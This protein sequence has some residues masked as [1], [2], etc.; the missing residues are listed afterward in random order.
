MIL[1][2]I[3][4]E[5]VRIAFTRQLT[6]DIFHIGIECEQI[7][8]GAQSGQFIMIKVSEGYEP[9][10]RRP[11]SILDYD[12]SRGIV[13]F[14]FRVV[15]KGTRILSNLHVG[16]RLWALGPLGSGFT[17]DKSFSNAVLVGGG[18]GIPPLYYLLKKLRDADK[19]VIFYYG[20]KSKNEFL[21]EERFRELGLEVRLA[22][23]DGTAGFH[24]FITELFL[25]DFRTK[26]WDEKAKI[27]AC[28][29]EPMLYFIHR[30]AQENHYS[31]ELSLETKMACGLGICQGCAVKAAGNS[32]LEYSYQLVCKDGPVF[33]ADRLI[34]EPYE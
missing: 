14:L 1:E 3:Y 16:E 10:L 18:M 13:E 23:D 30:N 25:Q 17:I 12:E 26:Q 19:S 22:T 15:G 34:M 20:A 8:K 27:F 7:G 31:A 5:Q 4:D 28:G 21:F 24:G 11:M 6:N 32:E 29:P 33:R 9:L 2:K